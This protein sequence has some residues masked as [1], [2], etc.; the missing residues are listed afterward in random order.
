MA[1][2]KEIVVDKIEAVEDG[3]VHVRTATVIK[4]GKEEI[5][6]TFHRHML[7]PRSKS[8]G[9]WGDT[10]VSKEDERT[11]AVCKAVW[12]DAVKTAWE[13]SFDEKS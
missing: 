7:T 3:C 8:D 10:D 4:D 1:L 5:T 9:K 2:K 6:R 11:Q 12:T 13:N